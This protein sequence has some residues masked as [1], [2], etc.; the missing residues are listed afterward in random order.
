M[1]HAVLAA[2]LSLAVL[3]PQ[4]ALARDR[5]AHDRDFGEMT[6][7]L[8][9]PRMQQGMAEIM[10]ALG[11]AL[12]S[13]KVAPMMQAGGRVDP[14]MADEAA[15]IDPDATLADLAGPDARRMP[16]RLAREVPQMMGAM[17]GM[18]G[19][20]EQM[21]PELEAMGRRMERALPRSLPSD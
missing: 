19:A 15:A 9:D 2:C 12:L 6:A 11:D 10:A 8:A 5:A 17:A 13:M 3:A 21:L 14:P 20:M 18:A 1:R 16:A 4:A 7:R